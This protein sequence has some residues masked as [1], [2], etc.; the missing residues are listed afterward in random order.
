[1]RAAFGVALLIFLASPAR[2]QISSFS[3]KLQISATSASTWSRDG[4][5]VILLDGPVTIELDTA[6]LAAGSAVIWL[7][8]DP[9][10]LLGEEHVDIVLLGD[11]ELTATDDH[12]TRSG[13][14][15]LVNATIRG[16]PVLFA[17]NRA[18]RDLSASPLFAEAKD[19]R[20]GVSNAPAPASPALSRPLST[21]AAS[22]PAP[23]PG[24]SVSSIIQPGSGKTGVVKFTANSTHQI[25][26][27]DG[28]AA[29][30]LSGGVVVLRQSDNGDYLELSANNGVI[31]TGIKSEELRKA[32][33]SDLGRRI[34]AVYLD[35]DVRINFTPALAAKPEGRL[36]ADRVY[37]D[38]PTDRAVMTGVVLHSVDPLTQIPIVIRAEKMRQLSQGEYSA[39]RVELTTS[40]FGTPTYDVRS[41]YAYIHQ[42]VETPGTYWVETHSELFHVFGI[43]VFYGPGIG[44]N[45]ST[46][47]IPLRNIGVG[48]SSRFGFGVT[49]DWGLFETLGKP[50]PKDLDIDY[51]LD[52][53]SER[54]AGTGVNATYKGGFVDDAGDPFSY[55]GDVKSYIMTDHGTDNLGGARSLVTPPGDLRGRFLWEHQQFF[56]E[57]WQVQLRLGYVSDPTFL[58]EYNQNE[59][60]DGLPSDASFYVKHEDGTEFVSFLVDHDT[61]RFTT[62]A[63]RQQEQFDVAR[64]PEITYDRIGD[65][66][67]DDQLTFFSENSASGLQAEQSHYSLAQQGFYPGLSPG[68]PSDGQTGLIGGTVYRADAKQEVD[69]PFSIGE[70]RLV[71]YVG[72]RYTAYSNSPSGQAQNRLFG[73]VGLR[74]TTSFWRVFDNVQSN[75]FDVHRIRH[76]IQPEV[77]LYTSGTTVDQQQVFIYDPNIDSINDITAT[78][79][80]IHQHWETMRGGP[81]RWQ[82]VD[83]LDLNVEGDFY[84]NQP[85]PNLLNPIGFRGLFFPSDPESSV[86]RQ[87][88]NADLTWHIGDDTAF[89]SD[90]NW[91][92][93]QHEL[94]LAEGGLAINRGSRVSYYVGDSYVQTLRTQIL[95][96]ALNYNLTQK[97]A[98]ALSQSLD[99][100]P[101]RSAVTSFSLTRR[102]DAFAL[103]ITAYHD[104]INN[105]SGFNFNLLPQGF[106][107]F[108]QPWSSND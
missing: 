18:S 25:E 98:V 15:L 43:P 73:D 96:G 6:K 54:G 64:L 45:V 77:N 41:S 91:N 93:D 19:I 58:E 67:A 84:A 10:G 107:G 22:R 46:D 57:G 61:T 62:N 48:G 63:D 92:L 30:Q 49:T 66:F 53:L 29:F 99:L 95:T 40:K 9:K 83:L 102:F 72:G 81:G 87:A 31:F 35:G 68:I 86:A 14:Q 52:Y 55:E 21:V 97:Y 38:F 82:S 36:T 103:Q 28:Y 7:K 1:M 13:S 20:D 42:S 108:S 5:N 105:T 104:G 32:P 56:P 79:I 24:T 39:D 65:S 88:I 27:S 76:I 90:V 47:P 59:F 101:A 75:L 4:E 12:V 3:E 34:S 70:L 71:P 60:D 100:G 44:L 89:I 69:W 51:R 85:P 74:L 37:Y 78:E 17:A 11:A 23:V 94:A 50:V 16:N 80:A 26:T 2:G 8:P 106:P 33:A